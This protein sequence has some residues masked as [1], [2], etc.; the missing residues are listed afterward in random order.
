ME[1]PEVKAF[2]EFVVDQAPADRRGGQDR[3]AH[4]RADPDRQG[5]ARDGRERLLARTWWPTTRQPP[6]KARWGAGPAWSGAPRAV[7]GS[8]ARSRRCCSPPRS[9]PILTTLA[10]V[11]SLLKET[12][13]FFGDVPIADYLF[14]TKW[15]PQFGGDQQSFG[16]L[17]L[18]WGTLYLTAHRPDRRDPGRDPLG[19]VPVGVRAAARAQG[20]QAGARDARRRA[21][22][23]VRLLRAHVLHAG[24]AAQRAR[25]RRQPV[26]RALGGHHPRHPRRPDDRHARRGLDVGRA[27]VAA[28]GLGR[29]RRQPRADRDPRRLPGRA[30]GHRRRARARARRARSARP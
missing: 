19:H 28:R 12:I 3:P 14:G 13:G 6:P 11:F 15:T 9:S 1:R 7:P 8:R 27:A 20:R 4:R 22:D 30:V 29:P 10:I 21:D 2:M 24:G 5:R 18:I 23:R 25:P 26:Q 16:V 17:P